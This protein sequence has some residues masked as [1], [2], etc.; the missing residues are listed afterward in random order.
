MVTQLSNWGYTPHAVATAE[1]ALDAIGQTRFAFALIAMR[2][3]G[4]PG[5]E[6]VRRAPELAESGPVIMVA[7]T[8]ASAQIVE[9]IQAGA[10]D[11]VRRPYTADDLE[12]AIRTAAGRARPERPTP[13]LDA[14]DDRLHAELALLVS[15]QMREIQQVIEQAARADVTVLIDGETGVGKEVAGAAIHASSRARDARAFVRSTAPR[16]PRRCSRASSSATS[17][18]PSPAPMQ[19]KPGLF[20]LADGGTLFLDEIGELP[21]RCRPS[22]CACSQDGEFIARRR[23]HSRAAST[24]ASSPPP[25]AT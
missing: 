22:C 9:A 12:T 16:C 3:P 24:C 1:E 15:P 23:A 5:I 6:L 10:D 7:E 8:G 21:P 20:E 18:A 11:V 13:A 17:A 2:L 19:R 25:T 4:M 14:A